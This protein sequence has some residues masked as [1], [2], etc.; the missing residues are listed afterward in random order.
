MNQALAGFSYSLYLLHW[1]FALLVV[2]IV[3]QA[4]GFGM[5]MSI[6][7]W[8]ALAFLAALVL[9]AYAYGWAVS[10]VTERNTPAVRR[11]LGGLVGLQLEP[12]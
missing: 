6:F 3:E 8:N 5:R 11:W 4:T 10:L 7:G 12:S 1:P 9:A 2:A